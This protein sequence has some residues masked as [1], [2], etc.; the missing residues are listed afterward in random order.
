LEVYLKAKPYLYIL[1]IIPNLAFAEINDNLRW[2]IDASARY[3][4]FS[5]PKKTSQI[6]FLGLDT[7]KVFSNSDGDFAY[8]VMQFYFTKLSNQIPY[9]FMFDSPDDA[10]VIV[11]EAHINYLTT[12]KW[13]PNIRLGHF[14]MPFGLEDSNDTNGRLLD[15]G[16]GSNLGTKLD[17]GVLLNKVHDHFEYKVS[18]SLGGKDDP[19]SVDGSYLFTGRISTLSHEDYI[20]GLSFY[21]GELDNTDRQRVAFDMQYYYS[22]WGVKAELAQGQINDDDERYLLLELNKQSIDDSNKIYA[23]FVYK[24]RDSFTK[25]QNQAVIGLS[26]QLNTE[27][28]A[29]LEYKKQLKEINDAKSGLFRAQIRY[30]F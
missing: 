6:Y 14:T 1:I 28:E 10:K 22:T 16:H 2:S 15:Y 30:R 24:D 23:Q 21:Y 3:N 19:K 12:D 7:H 26:F 27:L 11:R 29:S 13:V 4:D 17:W 20:F 18:Y 5:I 25:A 9:P 8:S